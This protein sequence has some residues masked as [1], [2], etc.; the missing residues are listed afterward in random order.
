V[1]ESGL[2]GNVP[3]VGIAVTIRRSLGSVEMDDGSD[4]GFV[5]FRAVDAVIDR[6]KMLRGEF[7]GP[8]DQ[9]SLAATSFECGTG[10]AGTIGPEAR[11]LHIAM[12]LALD[13]AHGNAIVRKLE[14]RIGGAG[15]VIDG[16]GD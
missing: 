5:G 15:A 16:L 1:I 4:L 12:Y 14:R 10:R 6:Q 9:D 11:G 3:V 2:A 7:V 8:F 13:R